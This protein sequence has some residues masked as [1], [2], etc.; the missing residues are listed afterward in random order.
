MRKVGFLSVIAFSVSCLTQNTYATP[1]FTSLSDD[2]MSSMRGAPSAMVSLSDQELSE[3]RGQALMSLNYIAPKDSANLEHQVNGTQDLG[4][5]RL[6]LEALLELNANIKKLQLGCGGA[7]GAGACDIDMDNVSLSGIKLDANGNPLPMTREERVSSSA[8]LTNPFIEFAIRNPEQASL[9]EVVGLRLGSEF[10]KGLLTVGENDGTVNGINT[11]SGYI[12]IAPTTGRTVTA[13]GG[14]T[15]T[16]TGR[17]DIGGCT[18][19]CPVDFVTDNKPITVDS[20]AVNFNTLSSDVRG[21]RQTF[22]RVAAVAK[23]PDIILTENSGTRKADLQGCFVVLVAPLCNYQ[24]R[25]VRFDG[26]ISNLHVNVD[27]QQALGL[28]HSIPVNSPLSLSLQKDRIL[29]PGAPRSPVTNQLIPAE[30]GWWLAVND[31]IQLGPLATSDGFAADISSAYPEVA[32]I[33]SQY[34]YDNPLYVPF[35][36]AVGTV[37]TSKLVANIGTVDL[38]NFT[39]PAAGGTPVKVNLQ[40]LPLGVMQNVTP[41]CYGGLRFC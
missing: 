32:R 4:F 27:L 22:A 12:N 39:N 3:T 18:A 15:D 16:I 28:V 25:D 40:N 31:P 21:T 38:N 30:R 19:G 36:D 17:V 41:N 26:K 24:I 10:A 20:M 37:F 5:Y 34:L 1:N 13:Q 7:N 35:S 29:W 11:L 6:G 23:V 8:Q 9:R 33:I 2:E 14:L